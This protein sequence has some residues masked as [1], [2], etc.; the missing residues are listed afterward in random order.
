[1]KML[2]LEKCNIFIITNDIN[3]M[4]NRVKMSISFTNLFTNSTQSKFYNCLFILILILKFESQIDEIESYFSFPQAKVL[5]L[6]ATV[7]LEWDCQKYLE[8]AIH[9]VSLAN[10]VKH[11]QCNQTFS[12]QTR[13]GCSALLAVFTFGLYIFLFRSICSCQAST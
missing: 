11:S 12:K 8:K 5:R 2:N 10:K 9:A 6:L 3:S 7:Y 1:M 13:F 4:I